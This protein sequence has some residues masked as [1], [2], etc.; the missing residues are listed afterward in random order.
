MSTIDK[1]SDSIQTIRGIAA[2]M[3]VIH[4]SMRAMLHNENIYPQPLINYPNWL[5]SFGSC[6]VDIF[7]ILS[8]F[9][10]YKIHQKYKSNNMFGEFLLLRIIRIWPMYFI[11]TSITLLLIFIYHLKNGSSIYDFSIGRLTSL[12]F[13]P[14]YNQKNELQPILGVGWTLNYEVLFYI[15]FSFILRTKNLLLNLVATMVIIN[16]VGL[17]LLSGTAYGEF[18]G[19]TI[20]L[21]FSMGAIICH[22][23][24]NLS[25][26]KRFIQ[27]TTPIGIILIFIYSLN[28]NQS[29]RI[30]TAGIGS[31][32]LFFYLLNTECVILLK[33]IGDASYSIYLFH[34][35]AIY[36]AITPIIKIMKISNL[37]GAAFEVLL[38][39]IVGTSIFLGYIIYK[40]IEE[41]LTSYLSKQAKKKF[42]PYPMQSILE[43]QK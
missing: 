11:A 18:M 32:L 26:N 31:A 29:T 21:E 16:A 37:H 9:L 19:N 4:H 5:V 17:T 30:L 24:Q 14:S 2:S 8:G 20:I 15:V 13:I 42:I 22:I 40:N 7:F 3:V 27:Y 23:N 41:P 38:A 35:I 43:K 39:V 28:D 33:K 6:G 10:M 36:G 1:K 12:L 34:T 25:L